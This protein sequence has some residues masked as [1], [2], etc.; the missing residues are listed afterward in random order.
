MYQE[1]SRQK[2]RKHRYHPLPSVYSSQ[3]EAKTSNNKPDKNT[4]HSKMQ[5]ILKV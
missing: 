3:G 1:I 5:I 2:K 4:R